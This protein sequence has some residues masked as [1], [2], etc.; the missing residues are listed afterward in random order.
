MSALL[1]QARLTIADGAGHMLP[2]ERPD[3]VTEAITRVVDTVLP[4]RYA[5]NR[6]EVLPHSDGYAHNRGNGGTKQTV[7]RITAKR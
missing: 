5:Q 3:Q 7:M 1:P 4:G 6:Q 2:L